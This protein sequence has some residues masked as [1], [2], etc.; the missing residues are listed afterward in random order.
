MQQWVDTLR[1]K[2]REMKI[3][4]PKDNL[5]SK[6]PEAR[7]PLLPTRDPMSPL[8]APPPVPAA[9]VPGV[10]RIYLTTSIQTNTTTTLSNS[11]PMPINSVTSSPSTSTSPPV[12]MSNTNVE[13]LMNLLSNPLEAY[14]IQYQS[15]LNE[16][17]INSCLD[18]LDESQ[19]MARTY[20]N[21]A[22]N[23]IP[24]RPRKYISN[25]EQT[26][27]SETEEVAATNITIIQVSTPQSASSGE[28]NEISTRNTEDYRSNVQII[29]SNQSPPI[30]IEDRT[31]IKVKVKSPNSQAYKVPH[32]KSKTK[33]GIDA[34]ITTVQVSSPNDYGQVFPTSTTVIE[35]HAAV[36]N[37]SITQG[38]FT[39]ISSQQQDHTSSQ[40]YEQVFL[41]TSAPLSSIDIEPST[42]TGVRIISPPNNNNILHS[43][44]PDTRHIFT[45]G[46]TEVSITRPSRRDNREQAHNRICENRRNIP[47]NQVDEFRNENQEQRRRSCSASD[48]HTENRNRPTLSPPSYILGNNHEMR[49]LQASQHF[50]GME[51]IQ[52]SEAR[53]TLREQQVMQLRREMMHPG[54][55]RVQLRR[56]D[57]MNSIGWVDAFGRVW[58]AGWKQKEHPV[59]YNALHIG[60]QLLSIAGRP[61]TT[62]AEANKLIRAC[63]NLFVSTYTVCFMHL[64]TLLLQTFANFNQLFISTFFTFSNFY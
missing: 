6:L 19:S 34:Q 18:N 16:A 2:L 23:N 47:E 39:P 9:L 37:I 35:N 56:K 25:N 17:S 12:V 28:T 54:G 3:L 32:H 29:P 51:S 48:A 20:T 31:E 5:Y 46:L 30:D 11:I 15:D 62:A 33:I 52:P 42:S 43:K 61:V 45:R 26:D 59:L 27:D 60:D 1:S 24:T 50:R 44:R 22:I 10:E 38:P 58:I 14:S 41:S 63:Q 36:T 8:P 13:N 4:S 7:L 53:I 49:R 64:V 57:C 21:H 55:V 40:H